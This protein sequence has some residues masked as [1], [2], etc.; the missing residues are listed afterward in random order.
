MRPGGGK[1]WKN[2]EGFD[3]YE[4]SEDGVIKR[5]VKLKTR[6]KGSLL[7]GSLDRDGYLRYS[8]CD[9]DG[10]I[11]PML[12]AHRIVAMAFIGSQPSKKRF[13]VCHKDGNKLNNHYSNLYWGTAKENFHDGIRQ[14][15]PSLKWYRAEKNPTAKLTWKIVR[16]L[17]ER[18]I[19]KVITCDR[20]GKEYGV[21]GSLVWLV[22]TNKTW[23]EK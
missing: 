4:I 6:R 21:T 17:R 12:G 15:K 16:E 18:Y 2:L 5:V 13:H 1:E 14:G 19:P 9:N 7:K 3:R 10:T 11:H 8:L 22:V 20:L 23:I